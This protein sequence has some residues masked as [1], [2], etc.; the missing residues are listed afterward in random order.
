[1]LTYKV[2]KKKIQVMDEVLVPQNTQ[3]KA[4]SNTICFIHF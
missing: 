1:M 4:Q 3:L 2:K